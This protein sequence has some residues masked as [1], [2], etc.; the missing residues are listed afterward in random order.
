MFL[1]EVAMTALVLSA[2]LFVGLHFLISS[3][4]L[5]G[6]IV[7][8]TGERPFLGLFSLLSGILIVWMIIAFRL[9]PRNAPVW[10]IPGV[11]HLTLTLMPIA[12]LLLVAGYMSRNPTAVMMSPPSGSWQPRGIFT[13]TRHPIMWAFGLWSLLHILANGDWAGIV[14][15][16]AFAVLSLG[17]TLAIDAK[18]RRTWPAEST[19]QLFAT[20]S[21][22]PFLAIAQGRTRFD[23]KN[24]GLPVVITIAL[25]LAIVFWFHPQVI[26]APLV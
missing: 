9:A 1:R 6:A 13:V 26:G 7:A 24:L 16:G 11:S 22:L 18:K 10:I 3:T 21:N 23:W 25:Y 8:R 20:T 12:L 14:F 15:F 17:G 5:R 4:P 2:L 19:R